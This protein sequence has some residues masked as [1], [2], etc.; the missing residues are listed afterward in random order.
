ML[1]RDWA[2]VGDYDNS[3]DSSDSKVSHGFNY[4]NGPVSRECISLILLI[5]IRYSIQFFFYTKY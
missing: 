1:F 4:H 2:Y 5:N 3:N